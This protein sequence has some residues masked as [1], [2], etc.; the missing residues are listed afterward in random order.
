MLEHLWQDLCDFYSNEVEKEPSVLAHKYWEVSDSCPRRTQRILF[1]TFRITV[2]LFT[3][4]LHVPFGWFISVHKQN[5]GY[6][7]Q[8]FCA[9]WEHTASFIQLHQG[10]PALHTESSKFAK[11]LWILMD[12]LSGAILSIL[13]EMWAHFLFS[14][15]WS[16]EGKSILWFF[17]S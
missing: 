6:Y 2:F 8:V 9:P 11:T 12:E 14:F 10:C 13:V 7:E 1:L 5:G 16:I 4:F 15:A 3:V 17:L